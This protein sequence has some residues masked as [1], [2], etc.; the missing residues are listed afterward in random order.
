M[1]WANEAIIKVLLKD[2]GALAEAIGLMS[3]IVSAEHIWLSRIRGLNGML[4]PWSALTL[5]EC[6]EYAV[7]NCAGYLKIIR[8]LNEDSFDEP[9][10][11]VLTNGKAMMSALGDILCHVP[12]H[13]AHHRGQIT[14]I[15]SRNN[16]EPP[17][18]DYILYSLHTDATRDR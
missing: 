14:R 1:C 12:V 13:G 6:Q 8:H 18:I 9:I 3:H 17:A 16:I 7:S 10:S 11:F 15:L 2:D 5:S 4:A